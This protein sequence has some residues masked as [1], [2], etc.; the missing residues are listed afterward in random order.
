MAVDEERKA[1]LDDVD[2]YRPDEEGIWVNG[3][4]VPDA[5]A[6][7]DDAN[8][9][10]L[11]N[12]QERHFW[13]RGRHRFILALLKR[14]A[15][16]YLADTRGL[17]AID[18]GCGCG[19]WMQYLAQRAPGLVTEPALGDTSRKGL[20]EAAALLGETCRYYQIDI[21]RLAWKSR[22]DVIFVL[23]VL[24]H[25]RKDDL[26]LQELR[27][28]LV[29]GGLVLLT[30][31]ALMSLWS[32]NDEAAG[33]HRRY[34]AGGLRAAA[35]AAGYEVVD[36]RYFMFLL[37]PLLALQRRLLRSSRP[38]DPQTAHE[39]I[40][41]TH[42]IPPAPVNRCLAAVLAAEATIGTRVR[43]PWGSSLAAVLRNPAAS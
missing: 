12:M 10:V 40:R 18:L 33:H 26:A 8:L 14:A 35:E 7:Y 24:E 21:T 11:R 27:R 4:A 17:R 30:V 38:P 16:R 20:L 25:I 5:D 15:G 13:Y 19:G 2:P 22:W 34:D 9:D 37:S 43:F 39:L 42:R 36:I 29:P 6:S 23:D 28:A 41:R 31:P 3:S 1:T 32:V